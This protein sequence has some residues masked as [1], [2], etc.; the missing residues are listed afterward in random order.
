MAV[1]GL[2]AI[3]ALKLEAV[4]G[5]GISEIQGGAVFQNL[6]DLDAKIKEAEKQ[7]QLLAVGEAEN[8]HQVMISIAKAKTTFEFTVE[9]RNKMLESFQEILRMQV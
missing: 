9:V 3:S 7:T 5:A 1:E 8:L 4:S 2:G 6:L